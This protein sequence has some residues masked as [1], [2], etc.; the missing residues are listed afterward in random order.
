MISGICKGARNGGAQFRARSSAFNFYVAGL[1]LPT[2]GRHADYRWRFQATPSLWV[3]YK[4]RA[5]PALPSLVFTV[6]D[7][8]T[9]RTHLYGHCLEIEIDN[10]KR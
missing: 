1:I 5:A 2:L 4:L 8:L 3:H 7:P 10:R 9:Q 6:I